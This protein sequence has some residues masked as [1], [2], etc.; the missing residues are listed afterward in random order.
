MIA[1][2]EIPRPNGGTATARRLKVAV[3]ISYLDGREGL[4]EQ[5]LY[6]RSHLWGADAMA[7]AGWDV[8]YLRPRDTAGNRFLRALDRWSGGRLGNL[9]Y[10]LETI[11]QAGK[12]DVIYVGFGRLLLTQFLRGIG[13]IRAR[14][15]Q[16]EYVPPRDPAW[17]RFRSLW[18]RPFFAR[19][20]DGFVCLTEAAA[21]AFR[22]RNPKAQARAIQWAP[23]TTMFPGSER[24]GDYFLACGRT[25]RD[26]ATLVAAAAK[27][28][29]PIVLLIARDLV[30]GLSIPPNV[31]FVAGPKDGGTDKGI[32]YPELIH[33]WYANARAV[34]I[35][36][37]DIPD[38]TSGFTNLLEAL[39]MHRPV[40]ITR[41]GK[42]DLDVEAAGV[43]FLVAPKD[44]DDW[45]A[46]MTRLWNDAD[47]RAQ[48]RRAA[49]A[50]VE[51]FYNLRRFGAE[52]VDFVRAVADR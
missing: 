45:A 2:Q 8:T 12:F 52:T 3:V 32:P 16:W 21:S 27:V 36:R 7:A 38:D 29:F 41:T 18:N 51:S 39:A 46:K 24:D 20:I 4:C 50:Q 5:N 28:N 14:V 11:R 47:L 35:P 40:L 10:D 22:A 49:R 34:L 31:R 26:Y 13:L 44:P 6:P 30:E 48:M 33:D 37:Q 1:A 42:L 19:G 43:G 25:N 17:W 15:M 23:D 9:D